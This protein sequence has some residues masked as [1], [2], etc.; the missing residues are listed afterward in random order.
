MCTCNDIKRLCL[1][2]PIVYQ[3]VKHDMNKNEINIQHYTAVY[4]RR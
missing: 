2:I 1:P 3:A 4:E